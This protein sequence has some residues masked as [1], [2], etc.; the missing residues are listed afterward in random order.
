M[1]I[2]ENLRQQG[3]ENELQKQFTQLVNNARQYQRNGLDGPAARTF[4][5]AA[6]SLPQSYLDNHTV[7]LDQ[8]SRAQDAFSDARFSTA[9]DLFGQVFRKVPSDL[10]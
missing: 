7:D 8:L 3:S 4:A 2:L 10:N 9:S 6:D 1:P 5:K